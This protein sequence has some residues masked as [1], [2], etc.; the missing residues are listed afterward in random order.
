MAKLWNKWKNQ[1]RWGETSRDYHWQYG[2]E[3]PDYSWLKKTVAAALF[4]ALVYAAHI[5]DSTVGR[6]VTGAVKYMMTTETDFGYIAEKLAPYAP[7]GFDAAVLKRVQTTVSKPADPLQYMTKPVDGKVL[8]PYG[9]RTHPVLK[10]EMMNEGIDFEAPLG[11]AVRVAAPGKVKLVTDSAQLGRTLIVD[12]GQEIETVYGHLGEV[13]VKQGDPVS[14]GQI[15]ARSGKT[16]MTA[17]PQLYFELRDKGKSV[18]PITRLR[19]EF[20]AKEGK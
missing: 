6:V 4:F 1:N 18:D 11:T 13:L 7:Q 3:E 19:G 14:Q 9:W 5:S 15:V 2:E 17:G 10:Q 12:H 20:P 8:Y 16:G